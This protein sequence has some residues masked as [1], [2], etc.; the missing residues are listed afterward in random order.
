MTSGM[1]KVLVSHRFQHSLNV[2]KCPV[3]RSNQAATENKCVW[4]DCGY[5][6]DFKYARVIRDHC[7]LQSS[8]K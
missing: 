5:V 2:T 7:N 1:K 3:K 6:G 8:N 4:V